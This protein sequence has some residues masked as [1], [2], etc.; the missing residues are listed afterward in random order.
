RAET[1]TDPSPVDMV[2]TVVDLRA[3]ELWPKRK[4]EFAD[5][6]DQAAEAAWEMQRRGWLNAAD[7]KMAAKAVEK[8]E[9]AKQNPALGPAVELLNTSAQVALEKL[10][11]AIRDLAV[12]RQAEYEPAVAKELVGLV[13]AD[14]VEHVRGLPGKAVLK[15]PAAPVIDEQTGQEL[16]KLPRQDVVDRVLRVLRDRGIEA[17]V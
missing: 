8:P 9:L 7:W 12:R 13:W 15:E 10:D 2:E 11:R 16:A 1:A 17:G 4:L 5:A 3:R 6:V 14:L